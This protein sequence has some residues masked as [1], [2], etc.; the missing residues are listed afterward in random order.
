MDKKEELLYILSFILLSTGVLGFIHDPIFGIFHTTIV[1][2]IFYILTGLYTFWYALRSN[3]ETV[4]NFLKHM[5][6]LFGVITYISI[7]IPVTNFLGLITSNF[8][9]A[10]FYAFLAS[11]FFS[12]YLIYYRQTKLKS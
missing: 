12:I 5:A 1:Q 6:F 8:I 7:A 4:G 9:N 2:N 11:I 10:F 3:S